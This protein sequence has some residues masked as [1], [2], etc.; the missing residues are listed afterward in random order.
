V[1]SP[2]LTTRFGFEQARTYSLHLVVP[3]FLHI[4]AFVL[5]HP[6]CRFLPRL[7]LIGAAIPCRDPFILAT[8]TIPKINTQPPPSRMLTLPISG[9]R[10]E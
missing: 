9:A 7:P 6:Q 10:S 1:W 3:T 8:A 2:L 4:D 5:L